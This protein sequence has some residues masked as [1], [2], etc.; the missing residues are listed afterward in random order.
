MRRFAKWLGRALLVVIVAGAAL[1][2]AAPRETMDARV[3]FDATAL[4][5]DLDAWLATREAVFTDITPGAQK[6]I[7]WAGAKG[8][9][10]P[11]SVIYLHG[12]S[13][14]LE[15]VRP[16]PDDVAKALG[17]NLYFARLAGHGRP[18]AAMGQVVA[19]DWITDLD[20]ALAIGH[21]LGDRV[22]VIA[23]STGG[24]LATL[25]AIDPA[26]S[27]GLAGVVL[28]SPNYRL[29]ATAAQVILD[30]PFVRLWGPT[31]AGSE[32]SFTP[33]NAEHAKWWTTRYPTAAL[34]PMA[35]LM[36]HV[37]AMDPAAATVPALFITSPEDRV[38]DPATT[39]AVA[40]AWGA[41][42]VVEHP[43]LTA[44]DDPW[45]HVLAGRVL[46]PGQTAPM[47]QMVLEWAQGL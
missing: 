6:Q 32:R 10:T 43:V 2:F 25:A 30:A 33:M 34:F 47:V 36:R 22:L 37:R 8:A 16:L 13:A 39:A 45:H 21:R 1:W 28:I 20:E 14:T 7:I 29:R 5:E 4:P 35:T 44:A 3:T 23:T 15:E 9:R 46:S 19:E 27:G 24:T 26:R 12:F 17:A 41:D 11:L 38:V 42:A 31:V 18:G 40:A